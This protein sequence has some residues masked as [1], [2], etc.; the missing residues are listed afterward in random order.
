[1]SIQ[2]EVSFSKSPCQKFK[3]YLGRILEPSAILSVVLEVLAH[4]QSSFKVFFYI[5]VLAR[6][7]FEKDII[8]LSSTV[9]TL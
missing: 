9:T 8:G 7:N 5:Q 1:M 3:H 2:A 6:T 4:C